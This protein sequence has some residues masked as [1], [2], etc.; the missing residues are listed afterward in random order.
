MLIISAGM[1]KSGSGLIFNILNELLILSG[2]NDVRSIKSDYHLEPYLKNYNCNIGNL[3][4]ENLS[5]LIQPLKD[6]KTFVVKTHE[7]PGEGINHISNLTTVKSVFIYRDPRDI[8]LSALDHGKKQRENNNP[9]GSFAHITNLEQGIQF[10]LS[11]KELWQ[12]WIT[13]PNVLSVKY[14]NLV[15]NPITEIEKVIQYIDINVEKTKIEYLIKK[16]SNPNE[17]GTH[18]N[19]ARANRYKQFHNEFSKHISDDFITFINEIGE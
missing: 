18:Y 11:K 13:H 19:V 12:S 10:A 4:T 5:K 1:P 7:K 16:Y 15:I 6:E 3:S 17:K 2:F 8:A 9:N 14:E